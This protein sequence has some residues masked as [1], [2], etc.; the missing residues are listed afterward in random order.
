MTL[1]QLPDSLYS[2]EQ[3]RELDRI[4]IES[5][6]IPGLKLMHR[7]ASACVDVLMQRW[8]D[9]D[10]LFVFCGS[11]NNAGDGYIIAAMMAEKN[12]NVSVMTIGSTARLSADAAE[13]LKYCRSTSARFEQFNG[14]IQ[15]G[16]NDVIVDALLGTGLTGEVRPGYREIIDAINRSEAPVLSVDIPSG[17]SA[18]TG[19][20]LG[21][22]INASTTVTFI[23]LK[24]GL[25]TLEG[26]GRRGELVY[27][28]LGV[29]ED[30]FSEIGSS[31]HRLS[32]QRL[33]RKLPKRQ[34]NAHK[35]QFGHVLVV[36]GNEGMGGAAAMA[37]EAA[38]RA[39][40]GLV[41]VATHV[42]HAGLLMSQRPELMVRGIKNSRDLEGL[43]NQATVVVLGPGLG[44][45]EWAQMLFEKTM[46][47]DLPAVI[48]ADGLN[49][50]ALSPVK[51]NNWILTPHPGEAARLL[52]GV[53]RAEKT[54]SEDRFAAVAHMQALYGGTVLL[55]GA[56]TLIK[57]EDELSLCGYGNPGMSSAGMGDVLSGVIGGLLAQTC[58][59]H[60]AAQLGV[61]VHSLAA[62]Q[63]G[64]LEG[65]RGLLAT[66]LL[67]GI[68]RLLNDI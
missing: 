61:V 52:Q 26:P 35:N 50:L 8:P 48:D 65:E 5:R 10:S 27:S 64:S 24:K 11:G 44:R 51:R 39:G 32:H 1:S 41:S 2:A 33:I 36:G 54:I 62:D 12:V 63:I 68:R 19:A 38:L 45:D 14:S 57:S 59:A 58:E 16:I 49:L 18:D 15:M 42:N 46:I 43:L 4:A 53:S 31:V 56:G 34:A 25:F 7:A 37:G 13:A 30:I 17:L 28:S 23:G 47:A 55:K 60:F 3:V 66:D 9:A 40:A 29:P 21:T 22:A 67:P 20:V 6:G